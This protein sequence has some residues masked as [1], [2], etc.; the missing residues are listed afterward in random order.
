[1]TDQPPSLLT[2]TRAR[3]RV[4]KQQSESAAFERY[5]SALGSRGLLLHS[6]DDVDVLYVPEAKRSGLYQSRVARSWAW[7]FGAGEEGR[8]AQRIFP[9]GRV[10]WFG[11]DAARERVQQRLAPMPLE[12]GSRQD[13]E[14]FFRS[15]QMLWASLSGA[16]ATPSGQLPAA[17]VLRSAPPQPV[18]AWHSDGRGALLVEVA[19]A[20]HMPGSPQ[21]VRYLLQHAASPMASQHMHLVSARGSGFAVRCSEERVLQ[22]PSLYEAAVQLLVRLDGISRSEAIAA[23]VTLGLQQRQLESP[24]AVPDWVVWLAAPQQSSLCGVSGVSPLPIGSH[25]TTMWRAAAEVYGLRSISNPEREWGDYD[26]QDVGEIFVQAVLKDPRPCMGCL[27]HLGALQTLEFRAAAYAVIAR[28]LGPVGSEASEAHPCDMVLCTSEYEAG[29]YHSRVVYAW[30]RYCSYRRSTSAAS[31]ALFSEAAPIDLEG[32]AEYVDS[33]Q[34]PFLTV[35]YNGL[36]QGSSAVVT[37]YSTLELVYALSAPTPKC[38]QQLNYNLIH[39]A[40]LMQSF[41]ASPLCSRNPLG[42]KLHLLGT[43]DCSTGRIASVGGRCATGWA[44]GQDGYGLAA[45]ALLPTSMPATYEGLATRH[46]YFEAVNCD[47]EGTNPNPDGSRAPAPNE[48]VLQ[49]QWI[50]A[51]ADPSAP[52]LPGAATV[53]VVWVVWTPWNV[54]GDA[55]AAPSMHEQNDVTHSLWR[56]LS[57]WHTSVPATLE[58]ASLQDLSMGARWW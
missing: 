46:Q 33:I 38:V 48:N 50:V 57:L 13:A 19:G 17:V 31:E 12:L 15:L 4:V 40:L 9:K 35:D 28:G 27:G 34:G 37:K 1:M 53:Q 16:W 8:N 42:G 41:A 5:R 44:V 56:S 55:S 36:W 32:D 21:H 47:F 14:C 2:G 51:V 11:D 23:F 22:V 54:T 7:S 26:A 20:V 58:A 45:G 49:S 3:A 52:Q 30:W 18:R 6:L 29:T 43:F 25:D 39:T 10:L 24:G